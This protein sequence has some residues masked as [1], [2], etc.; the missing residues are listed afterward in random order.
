MLSD[1]KLLRLITTAKALRIVSGGGEQGSSSPYTG[2]RTLRA[3][4][5]RL[6]RE[7]CHGDRWA[8]LVADLGCVD[9]CTGETVWDH[10]PV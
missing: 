2:K 7:R 8:R 6:T 9:K 4:R 3:V 10:I 5:S 1:A